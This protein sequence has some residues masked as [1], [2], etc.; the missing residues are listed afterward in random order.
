MRDVADTEGRRSGSELYFAAVETGTATSKV[1]LRA[2]YSYE[3]G[4]ATTDGAVG[5]F[6]VRFPIR[7]RR[8]ASPHKKSLSGMPEE[9]S[10]VI[11]LF[12]CFRQTVDYSLGTSVEATTSS[13]FSEKCSLQPSLH[14]Q[15]V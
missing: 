8:V 11:A 2:S 7:T 3:Q 10:V 5:D 4:N 1:Q 15:A 14:M 12:C 13:H 6:L 9:A